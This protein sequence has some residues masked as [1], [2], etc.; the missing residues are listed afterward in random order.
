MA[1]LILLHAPGILSIFPS[2]PTSGRV[3][4]LPPN[5][6]ISLLVVIILILAMYWLLSFFGQSIVLGIPHTGAFID[7]LSVVIVVLI[8]VRFLSQL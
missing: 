3:V 6:R 2:G 8:I 4:A 5:K 1:R 7:M